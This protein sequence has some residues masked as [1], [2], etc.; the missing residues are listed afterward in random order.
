MLGE[1][2]HI[3]EERKTLHNQLQVLQ[4]AS[5]VLT[6]DPTLAAIAFEAEEEEEPPKPV[7]KAPAA[8]AAPAPAVSPAATP[9]RP[10][11]PAAK[12]AASGIF[13]GT[14][15]GGRNPLFED[16]GS[17]QQTLGSEIHALI[18]FILFLDGCWVCG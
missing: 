15:A 10:S 8:F 6:R 4:K 2:P 1:P 9:A 18:L 14:P 12:P 13:G 16:T 5:A 11:V 3:L 7:A 17:K